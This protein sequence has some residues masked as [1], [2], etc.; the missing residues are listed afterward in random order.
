MS[1]P[2]LA[3]YRIGIEVISTDLALLARIRASPDFRR[4]GALSLQLLLIAEKKK[5]HSGG[6]KTLSRSRKTSP[7]LHHTSPIPIRAQRRRHEHESV[8]LG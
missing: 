3:C 8:T 6:A 7:K 5:V 1:G 4:A 2:I